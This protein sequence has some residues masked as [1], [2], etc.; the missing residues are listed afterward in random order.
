MGQAL[1]QIVV[2]FNNDPLDPTSAE[3]PNFYQ[4]RFT[5]HTDEFN[6]SFDTV[7]DLD[8]VVH[9]P[10][11]VDYDAATRR[12][13]LTF[14]DHLHELDNDLPGIDRVDGT[15]TYRLQ[16]GVTEAVPLKNAPDVVVPLS[17]PGDHFFTAED[18]GE[19]FARGIEVTARIDPRVAPIDYPGAID[20]PGHRDIP[21][22][23]HLGGPFDIYPGATTIFYNFRDVYGQDP[24]GNDLHNLITENQKE[25]TRQILEIYRR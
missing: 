16:I 5:G 23:V 19:V 21:E 20:E 4:L 7:S 8:D 24:D 1:D 22:E 12:A 13:V 11:S 3:N 17:D 18:L 25:L 9:F 15:G 14:S 6:A 10:E 2:H